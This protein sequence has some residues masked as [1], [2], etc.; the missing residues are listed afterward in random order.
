MIEKYFD[1]IYNILEESFP[2]TLYRNYDKQK[3]LLKNKDY[4]ILKHIKDDKLL[5]F[6]SYWKLDKDIYFIEHLAVSKSSR[7]NGIGSDLIK[8]FLNMSGLKV[9]EV[10][11]PHTEID[12]KRITLYENFGFIFSNNE[13]YQPPYND[14][15]TKT[16]L[17]IM[18][19]ETLTNQ[20]FNYVVGK[21]YQKVYNTT[22]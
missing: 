14:G 3:D 8:Q 11:P 20:R 4:H 19:T 10:E 13:Y 18:S 9:L 6:L 17:H 15:D 21:I 5:G 12:K 22:Y 16:K 7:K 2:K 1:D